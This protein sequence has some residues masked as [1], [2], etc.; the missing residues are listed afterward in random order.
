M[1]ARFVTYVLLLIGG[2][3]S[4]SMAQ[5]PEHSVAFQ[6]FHNKIFLDGY[7]LDS[8]KITALFDIGTYAY[9]HSGTAQKHRIDYTE[10]GKMGG[11]ENTKEINVFEKFNVAFTGMDYQFGKVRSQVT[12][13]YENRRVD[14]VFGKEWLDIFIVH[15]DYDRSMIHLYDPKKFEVPEGYKA[16]TP[17]SW[18]R[19]PLVKAGIKF[20]NGDSTELNMELNVGSEVGF[21]I[22]RHMTREFDLEKIQRDRGSM[23]IFGSD[24][25]GVQ[26]MLT[27]VPSIQMHDLRLTMVRGAVFK[28][29][30]GD[31]DGSFNHGQ[32]GQGFLKWSNLIFDKWGSKV[33]YK[34]KKQE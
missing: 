29:G 18:N 1:K 28:D 8:N 25:K 20:D 14:L 32:L 10:T 21:Q 30:Y 6:L 33:Y 3:T 24:G 23:R 5:Q 16:I 4:K 15:I 2:A 22:N 34:P 27:R 12:A 7:I 17:I 9:M 13:P 31:S 11:G 19:Y 26:G